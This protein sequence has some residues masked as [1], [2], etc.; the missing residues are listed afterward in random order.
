MI[1]YVIYGADGE[2]NGYGICKEE[3]Y[4]AIGQIHN[5]V[6]GSG[7]KLTHYVNDGVLTAY[8]EIEA[9]TKASRPAYAINWDNTLM[10]WVLLDSSV[11]LENQKAAKWV[12]IKQDRL[13][14]IYSAFIFNGCTFDADKESQSLI[15]TAVLNASLSDS[16]WT[17]D[18]IL[19]NNTTL[20]M[21][22]SNII[23]LNLAIADR[24]AL[25][26]ARSQLLR[27]QLAEATTESEINAIS[28]A[29]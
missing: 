12:Q 8:S 4:A 19:A 5:I 21:T 1:N 28:Y 2:I 25:A 10:E 6:E 11:I 22:K 14:D 26:W 15:A 7:S 18:W 17:I 9:A 16:S 24:T 3:D 29:E 23:D 13:S 27:L 20:A